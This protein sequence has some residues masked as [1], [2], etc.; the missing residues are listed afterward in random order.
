MSD[1]LL[2]VV[3]AG[4]IDA[5]GG[6]SGTPSYCLALSDATS[7]ACMPKSKG[8]NVAPL[9][10]STADISVSQQVAFDF[11]YLLQLSDAIMG[12]KQPILYSRH[13]RMQVVQR[14]ALFKASAA[15]RQASCRSRKISCHTGGANS[16][17]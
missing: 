1:V 16:L 13:I 10:T 7:S 17:Y 4:G 5:A 11:I 9:F 6:G 8:P 15:K 2:W 14:S 12:M 3:V